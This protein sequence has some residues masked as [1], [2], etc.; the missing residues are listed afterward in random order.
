MKVPSD[1]YESL[2]SHSVEML[3]IAFFRAPGGQDHAAH[4][5]GKGK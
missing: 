3:Y 5:D 4:L 2:L 1:D